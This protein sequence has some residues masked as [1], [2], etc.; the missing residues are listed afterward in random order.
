MIE[1]FDRIPA[2]VKYGF[3][4]RPHPGPLPRGEGE[5]VAALVAGRA[6]GLCDWFFKQPE[7]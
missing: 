7:A 1:S 6:T 5:I 3:I 2:N 4:A